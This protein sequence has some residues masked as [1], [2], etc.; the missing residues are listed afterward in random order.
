ML[1]R[2][3][4]VSLLIGLALPLNAATPEQTANRGPL[5]HL[6]RGL[7]CEG[8]ERRLG[9]YARECDKPLA[10]A[11]VRV[12]KGGH[13]SAATPILEVQTDQRGRYELDSSKLPADTA[14]T[15][16][17]DV[18]GFQ[19]LAVSELT[20]LNFERSKDDTFFVVRLPRTGRDEPAPTSVSDRRDK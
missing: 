12:W 6:G 15:I 4:L 11:K 18:R 10:G 20:V 17:W 5:A 8:E 13:L 7:V 14:L 2:R 16:T 1:Q 19:G 9:G 3:A